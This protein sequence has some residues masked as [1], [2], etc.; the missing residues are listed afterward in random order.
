[1]NPEIFISAIFTLSLR[2][3][4]LLFLKHSFMI[5][6]FLITLEFLICFNVSQSLSIEIISVASITL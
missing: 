2:G 4:N 3:D 1:M 5:G 6:T